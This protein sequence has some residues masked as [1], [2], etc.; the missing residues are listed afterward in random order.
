MAESV[1][2]AKM[3]AGGAMIFLSDVRTGGRML[4]GPVLKT[5]KNWKVKLNQHG[6][7]EPEQTS[8]A[9]D[10]ALPLGRESDGLL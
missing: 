1:A 8:L 3:L 7:S 9:A 2:A 5:W 6:L 10:V 4:H